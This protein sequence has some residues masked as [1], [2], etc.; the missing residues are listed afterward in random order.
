MTIAEMVRKEVA[1]FGVQ[2]SD[3]QLEHVLWEETGYPCFW[4]DATKSPAENLRTQ[5]REWAQRS[6]K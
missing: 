5:V 3:D 4:P 1:K 6:H 2:L